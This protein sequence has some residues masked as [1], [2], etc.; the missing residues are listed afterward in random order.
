MKSPIEITST[1]FHSVSEDD[2][3]G[4]DP[5]DG[6]NSKLFKNLGLNNSR[7]L[8]LAWLQM[9]KRLTINIR[10]IVGIPKKRNPKG[11]ALFILGMIYEFNRTKD[12]SILSQAVDLGNWLLTQ[13]CDREQWGH[14]CWGYHFDWQARAFYVPAGKPN[15][16]TTCYVARAL[17]NLGVITHQ[18]NFIN[19]ALDSSR[20]ISSHLFTEAD[21]HRF[22]AYIPDDKAFIHNASL[23]GAAWCAFSGKE[24]GDM[25]MIDQAMRVAHESMKEQRKDG[26]WVYGS[27]DHHQFIDGFHTGYN[28]EALCLLRDSLKT[29]EFDTFIQRGYSYYINN[30]ITD[31]GTAK[32]YNDNTY[33]LDMHSFSQAI[34]TLL[35]VGRNNSDFSICKKVVK[36]AIEQLYLPEKRKFIYQKTGL[37]TNRINYTRWTQAWAYY[38]LA[39]YNYYHSEGNHEED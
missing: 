2:F 1:I 22:Y 16:I 38:S 27:R 11:I 12:D 8:R 39:L 21:G 24:L 37:L 6:L 33:P 4:Y 13:S 19:S 29:S 18:Q 10:P 26:A 20:F 14:Y 7:Y 28:L 23:W 36:Q 25:Q 17:H 31:N 15:I 35:K 3:C 9:H 32:Y 30:L 5:F 34:I